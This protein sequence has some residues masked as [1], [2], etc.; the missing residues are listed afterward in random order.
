[1]SAVQWLYISE[2]LEKYLVCNF[3]YKYGLKKLS[4][5]VS[6]SQIMCSCMALVHWYSRCHI[7]HFDTPYFSVGNVAEEVPEQTVLAV[8]QSVAPVVYFKYVAP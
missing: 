8:L 4:N 5:W 1:M 7:V 6:T 3:K 2:I